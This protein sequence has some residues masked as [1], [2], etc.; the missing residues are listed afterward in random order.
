[1]EASNPWI[2]LFYKLDFVHIFNLIKPKGIY[3]IR[4]KDIKQHLANF[5]CFINESAYVY[6]NIF[7]RY[8]PALFLEYG[9]LSAN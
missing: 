7:A 4:E 9:A 2:I 3:K 1:M 6:C 5:L 8:F